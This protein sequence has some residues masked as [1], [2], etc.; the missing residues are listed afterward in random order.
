MLL[1]LIP[2]SV[3]YHRQTSIH[4]VNCRSLFDSGSS[5][6]Y[7]STIL[8]IELNLKSEGMQQFKLNVFEANSAVKNLD[9]LNVKIESL[10][11]T[12]NIFLKCYVKDICKPI[13]N[14]YIN[15]PKNNYI[16]SQ[17]LNLVNYNNDR[18][19][20]VDILIGLD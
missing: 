2:Q 17:Y 3:T 6:S 15:F 14:Q 10:S 7:V 8:F 20:S 9:Y 19:W 1:T 13:P 4:G 12:Q 16:H 5:F 11:S 18:Y